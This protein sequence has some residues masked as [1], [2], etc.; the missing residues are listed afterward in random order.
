[1]GDGQTVPAHEHQADKATPENYGGDIGAI[2]PDIHSYLCW[3]CGRPK[4]NCPHN[5]QAKGG[6]DGKGKGG[7]DGK[8]KGG[9]DKGKGKS[10]KAWQPQSNYGQYGQFGGKGCG[11]PPQSSPKGG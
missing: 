8:G 5:P 4:F 3:E 1:M 7:K 2:S 10:G 6:K 9:K 11:Q